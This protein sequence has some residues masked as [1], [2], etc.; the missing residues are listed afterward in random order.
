LRRGLQK[1]F[2]NNWKIL[3]LVLV[4]EAFKTLIL[5]DEEVKSLL[6]MRDVID[7]VEVAFREKGLGRVQMPPKVYIFFDKYSGDLRTMPS[8]LEE[9]DVSAVKVVNVHP[10]NRGRYN[11]PTVMATVILVDPKSGFPLAIMSGT[12]ITDMRTG[13]AGGIAAKYLARR[14]SKVLGLIGAG[15]QA[16]TQLTALLEVF[17][18]L[19][20][21]RVWSRSKDRRE[22][23]IEEMSVKYGGLVEMFSVGSVEEAVRGADIVVTATP[24]RTPLVMDNW[25]SPGAH[26]NCI[27]ADAPGKEELDPSILKRAKIVVDDW[28]QAAHSGEINVPLSKG[29]IS[30]EDIWAELGEVIAGKKAGRA[31]DDEITVFVSTGLALQDA[32][33]ASLVYRRALERGVGVKARLVF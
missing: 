31:S 7:A 8:Y 6:S 17:R 28:E 12:A 2:Y 26:F 19:D 21:V 20:E 27:G 11:L 4:M 1:A 30:E 9:I 5:N 16:R 14:N 25:V 32:V 18:S 33:T 29:F 24:S 10:E 13:A 15:A 3:F 22:E 23:F